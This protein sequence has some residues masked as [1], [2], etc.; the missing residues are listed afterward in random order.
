M[1]GAKEASALL[2]QNFSYPSLSSLLPWRMY[3]GQS[4]L[5]ING[6][7]VG[8]M[9]ELSP[10]IGANPAGGAGPRR[11][12]AR[13]A[14]PQ[15]AAD[16]DDGGQQVCGRN[17]PAGAQHRHVE[18]ADGTAAECHYAGYWER[19]ALK[20]FT[21]KRDYP[22]YLRN[23]RVFLVYAQSGR[24]GISGMDEVSRVRD[25]VTMP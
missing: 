12:A 16:R 14:A 1:S 18:G 8:F 2:Q 20:G 11:V 13:K 9:L 24:G 4:D 6:R 7:S 15:N 25:S 19:A 10:L 3:D 22:L 21:N 5:Y 17:A 23:Y